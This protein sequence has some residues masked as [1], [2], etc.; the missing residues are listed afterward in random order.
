MAFNRIED[1]GNGEED[2]DAWKRM[3]AHMQP[4]QVD[5]SIRSAIQMCWMMLPPSKRS[6]EEVER[7]IRR[8]VDRALK[9]MKDDR[10]EFS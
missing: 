6:P 2:D 1:F 5:Q 10:S 4:G 3:R 7:Q 8:I 9:N